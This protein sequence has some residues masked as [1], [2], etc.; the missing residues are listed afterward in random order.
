MG[1]AVLFGCAGG[2]A[3]VVLDALTL[4]ADTLKVVWDSGGRIHP[5]FASILHVTTAQDHDAVL[6]LL[7][8]V[9]VYILWTRK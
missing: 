5:S 2:H 6:A 9:V 8:C 1:R 4:P 3:A 7:L